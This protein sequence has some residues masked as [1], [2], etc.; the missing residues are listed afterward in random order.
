MS[1]ATQIV[2]ATH[3]SLVQR[4][5]SILRVGDIERMIVWWISSIIASLNNECVC[6]ITTQPQHRG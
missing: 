3:H 2:M 5:A 1:A 6:H 4:D